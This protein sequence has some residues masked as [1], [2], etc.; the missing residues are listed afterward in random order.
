M[1]VGFLGAEMK[2]ESGSCGIFIQLKLN[3]LSLGD[4]QS[5]FDPTRGLGPFCAAG[6]KP[7]RQR[8]RK[9]KIAKCFLTPKKAHVLLPRIR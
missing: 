3:S 7:P 2:R 1:K 9:A 8:R 4:C 6:P 5:V